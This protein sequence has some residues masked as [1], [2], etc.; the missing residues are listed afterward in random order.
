M[1]DFRIGTDIA[2]KWKVTINDGE[3]ALEDCDLKLIMTSPHGK[4]ID[5]PFTIENG[6]INTKSYG[7]EQRAV[8]SYML[9]LYVNYNR[10][11]QAVIDKTEVFNLVPLTQ[12]LRHNSDGTSNVETGALIEADD[13]MT[14][15]LQGASA[16]EVWLNN[17]NDGT[18][19]DFIEWMK[20]KATDLTE[21]DL[22]VLL[23]PA[24]N[25]I[26][27]VNETI[28]DLERLVTPNKG[29]LVDAINDAAAMGNG[30]GGA[31][32]DV[33]TLLSYKQDTITDLASIRSGAAKGATSVQPS[34]INDMATR[35]WVSA[36]NYATMNDIP[37]LSD[38][39][40]MTWVDNQHYVK[41]SDIPLGNYALKTEIPNLSGYATQSWTTQ[42]GF[43]KSADI[44]DKAD[45]S[46]ITA[47][48]DKIGNLSGL[49]TVN[50]G[51]LV[52]A[53][54]E[55]A[56]K[57]GSGG[58]TTT[59]VVNN[60]ESNSTTSALSAYQGN[61]LRAM[62]ESK[63]EGIEDLADI[64][65]GAAKGATAVQPGAI[66]DM[67][68]KT[69]ASQTY[70]AKGNY[71]TKDQLSGKANKDEIPDIS[72]LASQAEV[73]QLSLKLNEIPQLYVKVGDTYTKLEIDAKILQAAFAELKD[74]TAYVSEDGLFV[75]DSNGWVMFKVDGNGVDFAEIAPHAVELLKSK[76]IGGKGQSYSEIVEVA[77]D[78][79]FLIDER[80]D[81]GAMFT[82][83]KQ[84][85]FGGGGMTYE[86]V[87]NR[88]YDF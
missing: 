81:I 9:T 48:N 78:G 69:H 75:P 58:G 30:E 63:Q 19:D 2:I 70:Q 80:F 74:F 54:N 72:G 77:E 62:V 61:L 22:V 59:P 53:I 15:G 21:D 14:I 65:S 66:S 20:M 40:T 41:L 36:R 84:I 71:A 43:L 34:D 83:D 35:S 27:G 45:K 67:E 88:V 79:M 31:S 86:V 25:R 46:E 47:V 52:D 17:G 1:R 24:M 57:G 51:T 33:L 3:V 56:T 60:L 5:M 11:G 18:V 38:Y 37:S 7:R 26:D 13:E 6:I 55:A 42:Q 44:A 85:G 32:A 50:K 68:T 76:G 8:G 73:S 16:Y 49:T 4:R 29:T 82:K 10:I 87:G 64:R 39:A 28:G 23:A 12:L